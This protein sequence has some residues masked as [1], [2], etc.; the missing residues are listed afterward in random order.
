MVSD[1]RTLTPGT[2]EQTDFAAAALVAPDG[3]TTVDDDATLAKIAGLV[4]KS[5]K[6][7][8]LLS[9]PDAP[10]VGIDATKRPFNATGT[11]VLFRASGLLSADVV[12]E[13]SGQ[14]QQWRFTAEANPALGTVNCAVEPPRGNAMARQVYGAFC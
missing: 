9:R 6:H 1:G 2:R 4:E 3:T 11:F 12:V 13:C 10:D 7:T 14:E 8:V 5:S